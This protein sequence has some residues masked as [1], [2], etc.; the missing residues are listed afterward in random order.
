MSKTSRHLRVH[1]TVG[2]D[3]GLW[4]FPK[5]EKW[6]S[7]QWLSG[8][9]KAYNYTNIRHFW[10]VRKAFKH[11]EKMGNGFYVT[12]LDPHLGRHRKPG[13]VGTWMTTTWDI[14]LKGELY[15]GTVGRKIEI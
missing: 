10:R 9:S 1:Y 12:R 14:R 7:L 3:L 8:E 4:W 5:L 11:A 2:N 13:E 15:E 6:L